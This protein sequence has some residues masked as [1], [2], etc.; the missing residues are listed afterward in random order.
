MIFF[1]EI[2]MINEKRNESSPYYTSMYRNVASSE[3]YFSC[4]YSLW[5]LNRFDSY[6]QGREKF[7][8]PPLYMIDDFVKHPI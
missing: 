6:F 2:L 1:D 4:L 3:F 7:A 5:F 8:D